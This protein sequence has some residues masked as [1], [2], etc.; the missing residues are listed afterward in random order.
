[1]VAFATVDDVQARLDRPL[2]AEERTLA[3]TLLEDVEAIIR[4]RVGD[5]DERV[6]EANY[7]AL[8]VMVESNAVLRVIRNPT[9]VRS[10]TEGNY[11]Y[12]LSAAVASGHLFVGGTEWAQ[13]GAGGGA[14]TI[15]PV[16]RTTARQCPDWWG[17]CW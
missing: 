16:L 14:F 9:G 2:T 10:E 15:T 6:C 8:L 13:L 7:R 5:L 17:D 4:G 11:S 1:V 3:G 12:Q